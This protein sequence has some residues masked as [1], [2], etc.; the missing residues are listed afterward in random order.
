MEFSEILQNSTGFFREIDKNPCFPDENVAGTRDSKAG[1]HGDK[2][3][4][5]ESEGR[6]IGTLPP[7]FRQVRSEKQICGYNLKIIGYNLKL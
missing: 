4:K 6:K 2:A 3:G 5:I 1:T 7:N